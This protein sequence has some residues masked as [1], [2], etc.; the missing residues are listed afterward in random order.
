MDGS[1]YSNEDIK[2]ALSTALSENIKSE[3]LFEEFLRTEERKYRIPDDYKL[4]MF[5][6]E[7]AAIHV[8][9]RLNASKG[10]NTW[11][12]EHW[13]PVKSL[14]LNYQ[15]GQLKQPPKC[16]PKIIEGARRLS[17]HMKYFQGLIFTPLIRGL[18]LENLHL[19]LLVAKVSLLKLISL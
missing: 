14:T 19:H 5:N 2:K 15:P 17:K 6:G 3:F 13:N 10:L 9:N 7:V 16:L 4:Y 8:I 18:C 1:T 11:Y 12:D